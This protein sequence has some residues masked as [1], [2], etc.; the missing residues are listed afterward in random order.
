MADGK[1]PTAIWML[2]GTVD[3]WPIFLNAYSGSLGGGGAVVP[4][5]GF[6]TMVLGRP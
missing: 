1:S 3:P 2:R 4:L 5:D 6:T